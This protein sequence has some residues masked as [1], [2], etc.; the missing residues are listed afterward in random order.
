MALLS[1]LLQQ[2]HAYYRALLAVEVIGLVSLR[3]LENAPRLVS[4]MYLVI[5]GV[6]VLLDS[7]L[8]PQNRLKP[9]ENE[10][11][12]Q[13]LENR[14]RKALRR[15]KVVVIAWMLALVIEVIWQVALVFNPALAVQ[16]SVAHLVIWLVLMLQLLWGVIT[17]L[18]EEPLF[19]GDLIMGA[20]AGYLLVGFTGGIV[21][22][23]LLVL[24]PA[25]FNLAAH[26]QALPDAIGHAPAM[27]GAAFAS[28]TTMGS[29]VLKA[30]NLTSLT[31]SVGITIVGQLYVAI[32]IAGVLGKPRALGQPDQPVAAPEAEHPQARRAIARSRLRLPRR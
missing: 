16:L 1:Q 12:P 31:A 2:R 20:A 15:R 19:N 11:I 30:G 7:P 21:L 32:L 29:P 25:A 23:S 13:R 10:S 26:G 18:A 27:L 28:L 5:S 14:L 4:V 24:D 3:G 6:A 8:L 17:A 9:T 22:N